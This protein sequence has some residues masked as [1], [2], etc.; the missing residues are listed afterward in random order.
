MASPSDLLITLLRRGDETRAR[1]LVRAPDFR[2]GGNQFHYW[3]ALDFAAPEFGQRGVMGRIGA[4]C[5]YPL[6][7][8]AGVAPPPWWQW[9]SP[10]TRSDSA[11]VLRGELTVD[12]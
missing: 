3:P 5:L 11:R 7:R 9:R 8:D 6:S 2:I 4:D 10:W 1:S 12:G